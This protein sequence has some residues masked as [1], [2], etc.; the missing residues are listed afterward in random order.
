MEPEPRSPAIKQINKKAVLLGALGLIVLIVG[1]ISIALTQRTAPAKNSTPQ[2]TVNAAPNI[3]L[4]LL[5]TGLP[6]PTDIG[7][8]GQAGDSRIFVLDQ[9]GLIRIVNS[10]GKVAR[11]PFLDIRKSVL[12][13]GEMGLL[14]MAFSPGYANNGYFFINYISRNQATVVARYRVSDDPNRADASSGKTVLT[15][16]QPFAN[17]NGGSLAFG[18]DGYLY[19]A[20]G[21]GG[22]AGDPGNRAQNLRSLFG[23][24]LRL[25]V[26]SLPYKIPATNPFASEAGKA[27]EIWDYGLR[28]PWRLSFDKTT[29]DIY[30][31]DVGQ[32]KIEE[33]DVEPAG[34]KGG[35]NY[36]WRCLEGS[37]KYNFAGCRRVT[38]YAAPVLEYSHINKRCSITGGYV[39]RGT[40]YSALTGKYFYGDF[41]TGEL[42][43]AQKGSI[44]WQSTLVIDSPY[45]ITTFG[46]DSQGEIYLADYNT[47]SIYQIENFANLPR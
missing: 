36:G 28:N 43:W 6:N 30:I 27:G 34:G 39:Y 41:C 20:V 37:S 12:F 31:A 29:H 18:P 14:G 32:N 16:K 4:A 25:D 24:I 35:N 45:R 1:T 3:R 33:L 19:I 47:G 23:K 44:K 46:E 26:S 42:F 2:S 10:D 13:K 38:D 40:K 15:F 7:S 21:D 22:S 17:H 11:K 9:A 5:A 8:T